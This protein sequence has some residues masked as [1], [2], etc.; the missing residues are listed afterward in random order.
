VCIAHTAAVGDERALNLLG[1]AA[2]ALGAAV[3]RGAGA[4]AGR[5]GARAAALVT[6]AQWPGGTI[7]EL[8]GVLSLSHSATVRVVDGLAADGLAVRRP[9]GGGPAVQ[10]VLTDAGRAQAA[11]ALAARRQVL[12]EALD[13]VPQE[14]LPAFERTLARVLETLTTDQEVGDWICRLCELAT[15]PQESCPVE[16][17]VE[18]VR[19]QERGDAGST[20][21]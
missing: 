6:L 4:V 13:G 5:S 17:K 8:R 14:D 12:R 19:T 16:V 11:E 20:S 7:E 18:R 21:G 10:P 9:L 2:T 3:E 15:C 1:A